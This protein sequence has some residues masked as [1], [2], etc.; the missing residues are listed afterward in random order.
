MTEHSL[1]CKCSARVENVGISLTRCAAQVTKLLANLP[2]YVNPH[3]SL[4]A[5]SVELQQ[6]T[7]TTARPSTRIDFPANQ[8]VQIIIKIVDNQLLLAVFRA[9]QAQASN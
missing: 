2:Y 8:L 3:A 7:I 6:I 9:P 4:A 5:C 1:S